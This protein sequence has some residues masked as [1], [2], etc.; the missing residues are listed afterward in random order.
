MSLQYISRVASACVV[1]TIAACGGGSNNESTSEREAQTVRVAAQGLTPVPQTTDDVI[2]SVR[3]VGS[4]VYFEDSQGN[5]LPLPNGS[6]IQTIDD[7]PLAVANHPWTRNADAVGHLRVR[8]SPGSYILTRG[9][10]WTNDATSGLPAASGKNA[11]HRIVFEKQPNSSGDVFIMGADVLTGNVDPADGTVKV[12]N[13]NASTSFEQ[14]WAEG[15]RAIRARMPNAGRF[16]YVKGPSPGWPAN[17][18]VL[19]KHEWVLPNS[20]TTKVVPIGF[21]AFQADDEAYGELAEIVNN[22]DQDAQVVFMHSWETS[23]HA[24]SEV[25]AVG[26]R[27][28]VWPAAY[29]LLGQ[30]GHRQRFYIEN[31]LKAFDSPGEWFFEKSGAGGTLRYKP[32]SSSAST[33]ALRIPR[34]TRLL[35]MNGAKYV[36]F[37]GLK[38]RYNKSDR[39]HKSLSGMGELPGDQQ[40]AV[41][42]TAALELNNSSNIDF[43]SCEVSRTGGY[44]IWLR[45]KVRDVYLVKNDIYDT[46]A[47]GIK[48]GEAVGPAN[49][50]S[51]LSAAVNAAD[52]TGHNVVRD[53]RISST[54]HVYPG[55]VAVWIG[56]SSNNTIAGNVIADTTYSGISVG[57]TWDSWYQMSSGNRIEHNFLEAIG[58]KVLADM[59]GIYMLGN[60]PGTV[61]QG[62]VIKEVRSYERYIGGAY[63]LYADQGSAYITFADNIVYGATTA[64]FLQ[65]YGRNNLFERNVLSQVP[66]ILTIAKRDTNQSGSKYSD[67]PLTLIDNRFIPSANGQTVASMVGYSSDSTLMTQSGIRAWVPVAPTFTGNLLSGA[68]PQQMP[69][70][71]GCQAANDTVTNP[72][73]LKLPV[74]HGFHFA[75]TYAAEPLLPL[76]SVDSPAAAW[77]A[78]EPLP[79]SALD[80]QAQ[81]WPLAKLSTLPESKTPVGELNF[82][83]YG[84]LM[85]T[86]NQH[87]SSGQTVPQAFQIEKDPTDHKRYLAINDAPR[88]SGSSWYP[89]VRTLMRFD[90]GAANVGQVL[91][92]DLEARFDRN[93]RLIYQW[94]EGDGTATNGPTVRFEG[95]GQNPGL[96]HVKV[97][98]N[99]VLQ[100]LGTVPADKWV[101]VSISAPMGT[102][103][104]GTWSL[105]VQEKTASAPVINVAGLPCGAWNWLG[106]VFFISDSNTYSSAQIAALKVFKP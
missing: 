60:S 54:G 28:R 29:W 56:W 36:Q 42:V 71:A 30:E 68:D 72:G 12:A 41:S 35:D 40:A 39:L 98:L 61:V 27:A 97:T 1:L 49:S 14:L 106:A 99:G 79:D 94:R 62:N 52:Y 55:A 103:G 81:Q 76:A 65:H 11:D 104:T 86:G 69:L 3:V 63:G 100:S 78:A 82:Q 6:P 47:G 38:F 13:L 83:S 93:T 84:W 92:A 46:G 32:W 9:W 96:V 15:R 80:F 26:K 45:S 87:I 23:R 19:Q 74:A 90:R 102:N 20:S 75:G 24:V 95:D 7:L 8:F 105:V 25:D 21:E 10:K 17:G 66:G 51:S 22:A 53:N 5:P 59:G 16:Y 34:V 57:W 37:T 70:C 58:R 91:R 4:A 48:I 31:T 33:V 67:T 88:N 101:N 85:D 64:G 2:T 44:G 43:I 50:T 77:A 18:D 89:Y 73:W